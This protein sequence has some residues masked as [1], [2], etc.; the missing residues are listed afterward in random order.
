MWREAD[1]DWDWDWDRTVQEALKHWKQPNASVCGRR[2][3]RKGAGLGVT[4]RLGAQANVLPS[5]VSDVIP[6]LPASVLLRF[7]SLVLPL[8]LPLLSSSGD[9]H[10]RVFGA[11]VVVSFSSSSE[12]LTLL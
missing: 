2:W 1:G 4:C 6:A 9:R 7:V 10:G 3:K 11:L 12:R 8:A 5:T